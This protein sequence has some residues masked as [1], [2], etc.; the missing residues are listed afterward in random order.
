MMV[1]TDDLPARS[2][3][4]R[5]V[6]HFRRALKDMPHSPRSLICYVGSVGN[7]QKRSYTCAAWDE[8]SAELS[9]T[10]FLLRF[11]YMCI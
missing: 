7:L 10:R 3:F 1:H 6:A 2:A 8:V 5:G 4:T 11:S 9:F